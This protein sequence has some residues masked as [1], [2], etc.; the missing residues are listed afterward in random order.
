M[1]VFE[2]TIVSKVFLLTQS[3]WTTGVTVDS[4]DVTV[5]SDEVTTDSE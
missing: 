3:D 5:D 4:L 1:K 2:L